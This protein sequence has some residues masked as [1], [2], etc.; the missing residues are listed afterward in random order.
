MRSCSP[1]D[2]EDLAEAIAVADADRRRVAE[3]G[4]RN[5][6]TVR[7]GYRQ[8]DWGDALARVYRKVLD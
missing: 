1:G 3:I 2:A 6:L 7:K 5:A 4:N 8:V